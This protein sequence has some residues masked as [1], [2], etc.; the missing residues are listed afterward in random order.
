M[1]ACARWGMMSPECQVWSAGYR[2]RIHGEQLPVELRERGLRTIAGGGENQVGVLAVLREAR[3]GLEIVIDHAAALGVHHARPGGTG[4]EDAQRVP[5]SYAASGGEDEAFGQDRAVESEDEI[6]GQLHAGAAAPRA[7]VEDFPGEAAERRAMAIEDGR[8]S[9]G[10]D[11]DVARPDRFARSAAS[12]IAST[13]VTW[14]ASTPHL[15][16]RRFR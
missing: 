4:A 3:R 9:A 2:C 6:R 14:T 7:G 1:A 8:E 10:Y 12:A 16:T 11:D 15:R 5:R 13:R